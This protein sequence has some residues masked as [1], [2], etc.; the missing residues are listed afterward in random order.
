MC[1]GETT[2]RAEQYLEETLAL[3]RDPGNQMGIAHVSHCLADLALHRSEYDRA[4]TLV[5][6]SLS[7]A[8]NF[9]T[10]FSN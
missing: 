3:F 5:K 10:N 1:T 9:L 2:P 6:K 7:M 4:A 8:Q